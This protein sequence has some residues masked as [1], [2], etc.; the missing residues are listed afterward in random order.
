MSFERRHTERRLA[1]RRKKQI[2][3]P[4]ADRRRTTV[5]INSDRRLSPPAERGAQHVSRQA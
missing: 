3:W 5:R 1:D 4:L 2:S